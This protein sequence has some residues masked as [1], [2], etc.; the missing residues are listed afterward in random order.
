[1]K[2]FVLL[3]ILAVS[4]AA[5]SAAESGST[6]RSGAVAGP[7]VEVSGGTVTFDVATNLPAVS[8]H[9]ESEALQGRVR[10]RQSPGGVALEDLEAIVPVHSIKTGIAVRDEHMR[11]RV[12]M[13]TAGHVPDLR[14][15]ARSA[16][17]PPA[18]PGRETTCRLAGELTIRGT[19]RPF[20]MVLSVTERNGGFRVTGDGEVKLSAYSIGRP[21]QLLVTT[22]DVVKLHVAFMARPSGGARLGAAR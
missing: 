16:A 8:V 19:P 12:F 7:L 20:A 3:G 17:C 1:M 21:S 15:V 13:T 5:A 14:F 22:A 18:A 9:G 2:T 6:N 10:V 11:T 4:A